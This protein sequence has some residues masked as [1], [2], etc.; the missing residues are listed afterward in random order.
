MPNSRRGEALPN[1]GRDLWQLATFHELSKLIFILITGIATGRTVRGS[2]PVGARFSTPVQNGP[3]DH[4]ASYTMVAGSFPGRGVDHPPQSS[5]EVKGRVEL[6]ICSSSGPSWPVLG[7]TLP[8]LLSSERT[9]GQSLGTFKLTT[10]R[11]YIGQ[12]WAKKYCSQ[13]CLVIEKAK[14]QCLRDAFILLIIIIIII[15]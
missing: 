2:I 14:A 10:V 7:S 6:Y 9:S 5:A 11:S 1:P 15:I 12:Q 4:P 3:G 13:L 8:L